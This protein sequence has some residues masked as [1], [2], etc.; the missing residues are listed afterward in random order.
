MNE[1]I[2]NKLLEWIETAS[3]QLWGILTKQVSIALAQNILWL[4][5]F[6]IGIFFTVKAI[7]YGEKLKDEDYMNDWEIPTV[8][9]WCGLILFIALSCC[10]VTDLINI[11][12]NPE[13]YA[14]QLLINRITP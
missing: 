2:L 14:I 12:F 7:K 9:G 4:G 8:G 3:P 6:L 1:E 5:L 11:I 13:W 10:M